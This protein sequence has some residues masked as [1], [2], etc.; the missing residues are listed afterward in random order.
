MRRFMAGPAAALLAEQRPRTGL[1][2][3]SPRL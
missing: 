1:A 2:L 3:Y